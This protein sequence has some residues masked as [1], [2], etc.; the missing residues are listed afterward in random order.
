MD[1]EIRGTPWATAQSNET[2]G[3]RFRTKCGCT[4][5]E[6]GREEGRAVATRLHRTG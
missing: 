1:Q 2:L 5:L 6:N 4:G 3:V